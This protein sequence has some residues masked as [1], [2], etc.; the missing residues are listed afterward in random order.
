MLYPYLY[1]S[2]LSSMNKM[3]PLRLR[4]TACLITTRDT[5]I[6]IIIFF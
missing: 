2:V 4:T 3:C 5:R 1:R 6:D